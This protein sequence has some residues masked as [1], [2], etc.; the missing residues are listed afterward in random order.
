MTIINMLTYYKKGTII[1]TQGKEH[2]CWK[3]G[4]SIYYDKTDLNE[5]MKDASTS[6]TLV[7]GSVYQTYTG[8]EY[9]RDLQRTDGDYVFVKQKVKNT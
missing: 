8:K 1:D 9:E 5:V 4:T 7:T 2:S 6:R 3:S